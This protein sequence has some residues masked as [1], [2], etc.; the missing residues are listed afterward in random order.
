[1]TWWLRMPHIH[2]WRFVFN[3]LGGWIWAC[4]CGARRNN[5]G[6]I[7]TSRKEATDG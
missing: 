4:P 5:D 1:M 7:I 6:R 3:G 2:T